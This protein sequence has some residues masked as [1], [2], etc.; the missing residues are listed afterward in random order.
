[1]SSKWSLSS[2]MAYVVCSPLLCQV[3]YMPHPSNSPWS[4]HANSVWWRARTVKLLSMQ[5]FS[6]FYCFP[7]HKLKYS[8]QH[9]LS[10]ITT[11]C[12]FLIAKS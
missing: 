10:N 12:S 8:P 4:G 6:P 7:S 3:C 2:R 11:L 5:S 9:P 1:M